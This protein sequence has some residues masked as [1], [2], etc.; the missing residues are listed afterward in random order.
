MKLPTIVLIGILILSAFLNFYLLGNLHPFIGDQGWFYLSALDLLNGDIPLVGITASYTWLSQGA[1][2]T[3]MLAPFLYIFNLDPVGGAYL[4]A[5]LGVLSVLMM[6]ILT[7]ELFKSKEM[8]LISASLMAVSPLSIAFFRMPYHTSPIP[9]A[10]LIFIYCLYKFSSGKYYY[11]PL[12]AFMLGI[13]YNLALVTMVFWGITFIVL[14]KLRYFNL[15][16][17]FIS[18]I[19]FL[20]PMIPMIVYDFSKF[21]GF[22]QLTAMPRL[23]KVGLFD[24]SGFDP[25]VYLNVFNS[26]LVYNQKLIFSVNKILSFGLV[27][28]SMLFLVWQL[29]LNRKK[30]FNNADFILSLW[31]FIPIIGIFINKTPSEAYLPMFYPGII[32]LVAYVFIKIIQK[33]KDFRPIIY[34]LFLI[35][36]L[37]NLHLVYSTLYLTKTTKTIT[38]SDMKKVA[39]EIVDRANGKKYNLVS[40]GAGSEFENNLKNFEYLTIWMG[41][42]PSKKSENLRFKIETRNGEIILTNEEKN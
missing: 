40:V 34:A 27:I 35:I 38:V 21:S 37:T 6:Y 32:L 36:F 14:I 4:S 17:Y 15:K 29:F 19:S 8:A 42:G 1:L 9:L 26:L 22:Y 7:K 11:L 33:N 30:D 18:F 5:F 31:V 39:S 25:K 3:Y 12:V 20:L 28:F 13:L 10:T 2:W 41:N 16:L 23:I 24:S